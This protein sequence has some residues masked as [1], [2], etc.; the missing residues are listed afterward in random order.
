[1][2]IIQGK[3]IF[4]GIAIGPISFFAKE[5]KQVKRTKVEDTEAEIARYEAALATAIEQL[6]AL[7]EKALKEVGESEAQ[8]FEVHQ[9][10]LE[11]DDYNDSVKNIITSQG[12][13]A[14]FAVATTGDNFST[15][16]AAMDDEYFQ[17]RAVDVKDISERIINILMGIGEAKVSDVP[18]IIVAED[19]APSETVQ[20]DKSKLL[21]F[22]TRLGS[23]NSHTAILARTMNIP[24]LI[25][26][27]IKEEWN[28]KQAIIDGFSGKFIIEPEAD[29]LEEYQKKQAEQ[30]ERRRLLAEQKGKP[31]VTKNGKAIKL[32][33]NIGSVSDL[34]SVMENDAAG[35]GLF[36]S[37]FLYLESDTYPTEEEQF[38]AYKMVAE[39][40]AGKKVIIRTLDIGA[41]KQVDYFELD[42]EENPAMGL[43]AIRICLTRTEIFK[44]QLRALLRASAFGNIAVMYPMIISVEEV[45]KIKAIM[46]EVKAELDEAGIPYGNVEQGIMIETPAAVILSDLLAKEVDFF[47]IG[48]NDLTQYTLAIDRQNAKLDEFYNP[49]HEAVLRMIQMVVENAHKAGIWAGICGELGADLELTD[50]FMEMGVDELSV[51]PTFIYPVRQKIREYDGET[52]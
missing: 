14:E 1:M 21:G 42:K 25:Q 35:I 49:H 5:Q 29:V 13:N 31:T 51:S 9:M 18:S 52:K 24:A 2:E 41:D 15:M 11:D 43:R 4:G 20:M 34:Q 36:R 26:V 48:T 50:R 32:F 30:Q 33:A 46:E 12:L 47:S 16:F 28:G 40:M 39:T 38:K 45:R 8:I 37:E 19:L 10:M 3:A 27:D 17:A 6:G 44:T 22:V 7:Y 23:S